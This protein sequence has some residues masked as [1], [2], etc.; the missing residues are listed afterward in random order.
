MAVEG[1]VLMT[2]SS[3]IAALVVGSVIG[4]GGRWLVPARRGM[5]GWLLFAV[6]VGAA[7]LG[8]ITARLISVDSTRVSV[9]EIILQVVFAGVAVTLV[10][11][12]ADR[13]PTEDRYHRMGPP[14]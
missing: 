6:G 4:V 14:R 2:I 9:V 8:T 11:V 13:R 3:L 12:T 1:S 10:A 5:P 7:A